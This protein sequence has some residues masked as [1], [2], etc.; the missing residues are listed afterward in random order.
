MAL[1]SATHPTPAGADTGII[2]ASFCNVDAVADSHS[3]DL[4]TGV[5]TGAALAQ[6]RCYPSAAIPSTIVAA[7]DEIEVGHGWKVCRTAGVPDLAKARQHGAV[8]REWV[9]INSPFGLMVGI[10][11]NRR[12]AKRPSTKIADG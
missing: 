1:A 10:K 8:G 3:E 6:P 12:I 4:V 2:D 9:G 5:E 11:L 7:G